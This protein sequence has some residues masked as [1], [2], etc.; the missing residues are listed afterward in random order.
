MAILKTSFYE[1]YP[2]HLEVF[3]KRHHTKGTVSKGTTQKAQCQKAPVDQRHPYSKGTQ[4]KAQC[5]KAPLL[6]GTTAKRHPGLKSP[7]H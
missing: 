4:Q 5:Q 3:V 7:L 6:K 1:M 2:I